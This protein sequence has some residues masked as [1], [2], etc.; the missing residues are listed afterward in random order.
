MHHS[1]LF[2]QI[3]T[4]ASRTQTRSL[5]RH[6]DIDRDEVSLRHIDHF[7]G[8]QQGNWDKVH[9]RNEPNARLQGNLFIVNGFC[10]VRGIRVYVPVVLAADTRPKHRNR[11]G[12][13]AE[14]QLDQHCDHDVSVCRLGNL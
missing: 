5:I 13:Q 10:S 11:A 6:I 1:E 7:Q 3:G 12:N 8:D 4:L 14:N 2:I 9:K